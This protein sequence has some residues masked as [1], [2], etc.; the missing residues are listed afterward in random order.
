MINLRTGGSPIIVHSPGMGR[1]DHAERNPCWGG[2]VSLS[3][4]SSSSSPSGTTVVL[5][6]NLGDS[7]AER[8]LRRMGVG[9]VRLGEGLSEWNNLKKVRLMGEY[10][11]GHRGGQI[12]YIDSSDVVVVGDLSRLDGLLGRLGCGMLF[13][14]ETEF[15]PSCPGFGDLESWE[16]SVS[17]NDYFALNAGCWLADPSFLVSL[18]R[19]F[20]RLDL[21]AHLEASRGVLQYHTV[22]K[23]DQ[24]RWHLIYRMFRPSVRLDHGCDVFQTTFLHSPSDF[25]LSRP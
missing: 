12:L 22:A 19:E 23:D 25:D 4:R 15:Y 7:V 8:C 18:I 6:N 16:R 5:C 13:S 24:F 9:Y 17:P 10:L 20:W 1:P 3:E 21:S 2:F 14:A 11:K